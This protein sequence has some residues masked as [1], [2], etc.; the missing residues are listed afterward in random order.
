[1]FTVLQS[2]ALIRVFYNIG[3]YNIT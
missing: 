2:T 1:M 3:A